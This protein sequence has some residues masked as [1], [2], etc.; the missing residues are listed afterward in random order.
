MSPLWVLVFSLVS[1]SPTNLTLHFLVSFQK[2]GSF[3]AI[4]E[5]YIAL[6]MDAASLVLDIIVAT[7]EDTINN[8]HVLAFRKYCQD[9]K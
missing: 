9:F 5:S 3:V 8:S 4:I 7:V 1:W 6:A 2:F